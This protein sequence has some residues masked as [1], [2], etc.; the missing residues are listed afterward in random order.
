MTQPPQSGGAVDHRAAAAYLDQLAAAEDAVQAAIEHRDQ[1]AEQRPPGVTV[2]QAAA[3][4]R[5]SVR[6]LLKRLAARRR[7]T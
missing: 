1:L 5:V 7:S 4:L 6:G 3:A 2:Q